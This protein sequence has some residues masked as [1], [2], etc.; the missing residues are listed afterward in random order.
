MDLAAHT[1]DNLIEI[2]MFCGS[3]LGSQDANKLRPGDQRP[4]A[5]T[6]L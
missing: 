1:E 6:L 4:F 2:S 5:D 3:W